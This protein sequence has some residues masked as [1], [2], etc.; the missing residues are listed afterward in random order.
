MS[1]PRVRIQRTAK[2]GEVIEI[3]TLIDHPMESGIRTQ[4]APVARNILA[5]FT[6]TMNGAP[7]FQ[8]DFGNGASANPYFVFFAKVETTS[9]FAFVWTH[10][11][12]ETFR[13]SATVRVG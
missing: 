3:R 10:E 6:A 2:P 9:E 7:L 11:N 12:G 4:S 13:A 1:Q 8:A 5:T